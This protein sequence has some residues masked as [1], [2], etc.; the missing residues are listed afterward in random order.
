MGLYRLH[1]AKPKFKDPEKTL[2]IKKVIKKD[3][4]LA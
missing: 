2:E 1:I 4:Q 3:K